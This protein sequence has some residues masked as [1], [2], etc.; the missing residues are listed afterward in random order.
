MRDA[1]ESLIM[2]LKEVMPESE[3]SRWPLTSK[4]Q[5]SATESDMETELSKR[6]EENKRLR[7]EL[8][9]A[10]R[11]VQPSNVNTVEEVPTVPVRESS[12]DWPS[13]MNELQD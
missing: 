6:N 3:L 4:V 7:E 5:K 13:D 2:L 11:S 9:K 8:A 1:V 12:V 10:R